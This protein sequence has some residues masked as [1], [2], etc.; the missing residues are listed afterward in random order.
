MEARRALRPPLSVL[1]LAD[2]GRHGAGN[3]LGHIRAFGRYSR[4]DVVV[5]NPRDV[6]V[7]RF[8]RLADFDV[9]VVHYSLVL[10]ADSYVPPWLRDQ[11]RDFEGLKV[12]FLQ[13]EYRWVDSITEMARAL[14]FRMLFTIVPPRELD[15]VYGGRLP[16]VVLVPTLAGFVPDELVQRSSPPL[17]ARR[18]DIGYRGRVLPFWNG[19]LSQEKVSIGKGV[20]ARAQRY[21][22]RC[23]IA[24]GENDRL[25][26]E[27]WYRFLESCRATLGTESGTSITDF[28]GSVER[29]T[30]EYLAT[31]P[32]ATFEQASEAV[33]GRYEG[34]VMMNVVSP[35]VFE[36][37]ALRTPMVLFPGEYGGVIRPWEHYVPLE[38]DFSNMDEVVR[39]IR[40]APEMQ[41]MI[42]RARSDV[43]D[44]GRY[45]LRRFIESFDDAIEAHAA[46]R[47]MARPT[48]ARYRLA[49]AERPFTTH[50]VFGLDLPAYRSSLARARATIRLVLGDA[51]LRS[52]AW[53]FLRDETL[54]ETVRPRRLGRD[55]MRLGL[56][57]GAQA[58]RPVVGERFFVQPRL[59][60]A[61][62]TLTLV[63]VARGS[64][65]WVPVPDLESALRAGHVSTVV[66]DHR[67]LG[68][69]IHYRRRSG[70]WFGIAVGYYGVMGVHHLV[71][72]D[73]AAA[74]M[75]DAAWRILEP[76]CSPPPPPLP[77]MRSRMLRWALQR[78]PYGFVRR[79]IR[80][81][82]MRDHE[83]V[84]FFFAGLPSV[85]NYVAKAYVLGKLALLEPPLRALTLRMLRDVELRTHLGARAVLEDILKLYVIH[86]CRRGRVS[87]VAR[88]EVDVVGSTLRFTT[89]PD[90]EIAYD[91][92]FAKPASARPTSI[93]WDNTRFGNQFRFPLPFGRRMMVATI[94]R[95]VHTF[96]TFNRLLQQDAADAW[97]ALLDHRSR[98]LTPIR[99][100]LGAPR[101]YAAKAYLIGAI[102][103]REPQ[104]RG[105]LLAY[106]RDRKL[107]ELVGFHT[108]LG[109]VLKLHLL[110]SAAQGGLPSAPGVEI[111]TEGNTV[112]A[113]TVLRPTSGGV[114]DL[115]RADRLAWDHTVC[116]RAVV[117][118]T[119]LK[120]DLRVALG[121]EGVHEFQLIAAMA[122]RREGMP[123]LT[124]AVP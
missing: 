97:D 113:R 80:V 91:N 48:R 38:K 117:L 5:F 115:E 124:G 83:E 18:L 23:D 51:H 14:R 60:S 112:R 74:S 36:A 46:P 72:L 90:G 69:E 17:E 9:V 92:D 53:L 100:L 52:F 94:P 105:L 103:A 30:V 42:E 39:A 68:L 87:W 31:H 116:G 71:T 101:N 50:V 122:T 61:N 28:D 55:L 120:S 62:E 82:R 64:G 4:H 108:A 107:R 65:D 11:L 86:S 13:D 10:I 104:L 57:R 73:R 7:S 66:W 88:A 54:R 41:A 76:L 106:A 123:R 40:D 81:E 67:P 102:L 20:L 77:R 2:D 6:P 24:W 84:P 35:R 96:A 85:R 58:G 1:V 70:R 59:D 27:Q 63:S 121:S 34:N 12:L 56:L 95:G 118:Q 16:G 93:E 110:R 47:A 75:P 22:L 114:L 8:L 45:S 44:S 111:T 21:G 33:L 119:F 79:R 3:L 25:Y 29:E 32:A 43:V 49:L 19:A 78:T 89:Y 37:S 98:R 99:R 26:G 15:K 109:D